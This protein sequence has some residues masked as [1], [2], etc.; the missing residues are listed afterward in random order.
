M[1]GGRGSLAIASE[2]GVEGGRGSLAIA[3][4][5]GVHGG[6]G[7]RVRRQGVKA[8]MERR[9]ATWLASQRG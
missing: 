2:A 4:E 3:S 5:V 8:R 9:G 6:I 7:D 1:E